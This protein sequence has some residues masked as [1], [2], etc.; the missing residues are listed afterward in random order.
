LCLELRHLEA[1]RV[2]GWRG[3]GE[4]KG[5]GRETPFAI[6][7][8]VKRIFSASGRETKKEKKKRKKKKSIALHYPLRRGIAN[9]VFLEKKEGE[10]GEE[11]TVSGGAPPFLREERKKGG[12][13][14]GMPRGTPKSES[15]F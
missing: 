10:G 15:S 4:R 13:K 6:G 9:S 8:G 12:G 2:V 7:R 14:H 11:G 5:G 3:K 1:F